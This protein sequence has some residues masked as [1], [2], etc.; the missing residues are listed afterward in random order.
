MCA[1]AGEVRANHAD[2]QLEKLLIEELVTGGDIP[3][4]PEFWTDLRR[5]AAKILARH[6]RPRKAH[7]KK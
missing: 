5:D 3:L 7:A 4:S 1:S 6:K 2:L